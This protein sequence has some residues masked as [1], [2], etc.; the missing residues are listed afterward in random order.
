MGSLTSGMSKSCGCLNVDTG[1]ETGLYATKTHGG[2]SVF[3]SVDDRVKF[4]ILQGLRR[5]ARARGYETDL[6]MSDLPNLGDVCPVLGVKFKKKKGPLQEESVSLDRI[7]SNL[8]YL[9]KYKDNL[10]FIS[11]KANRIKNDATFD[12]LKK[13]VSYIQQ[14]T[15]SLRRE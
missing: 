14:H 9:K 7:N 3:A 15:E 12:D 11:H 2:S 13:V 8:P 5:R 1:R 4:Q 6:E 10:V